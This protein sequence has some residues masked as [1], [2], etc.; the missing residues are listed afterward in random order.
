[1]LVWCCVLGGHIKTKPDTLKSDRDFLGNPE[2]APQVQVTFHADLDPLGL[3]AHRRC[4]HLA[5]NLGTGSKCAQQQIA[6][7]RRCSVTAYT[8]MRLRVIDGPS[9]VDRAGDWHIGF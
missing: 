7:T 6:R 9:D 3:N 8:D 1:Q 4:D 5:S 2:R